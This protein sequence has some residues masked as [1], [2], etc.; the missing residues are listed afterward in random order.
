MVDGLFLHMLLWN[1]ICDAIWE[2]LSDV[3]KLHF[4][5]WLETVRKLVYNSI[6]HFRIVSIRPG[7]AHSQRRVGVTI[8]I[9][10]H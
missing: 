5:K 4:E 9:P 2:N 1:I 7:W 8:T 6:D 10:L 3:T